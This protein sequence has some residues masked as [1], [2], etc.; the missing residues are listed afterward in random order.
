M[1]LTQTTNSKERLDLLL[2]ISNS[3]M[4]QAPEEAA[5]FARQAL[6]EAE[7]T[8]DQKAMQRAQLQLIDCY[9]PLMKNDSA[10]FLLETVLP[11]LPPDQRI[12]RLVQQGRLL[13]RQANY[14]EGVQRVFEA[15]EL[16]ESTGNQ[17]GQAQA[18]IELSDLMYYRNEFE[19]SVGFAQQAVDL[20]DEQHPADLAMAYQYMA[21]SY[22]RLEQEEL[23]LT[24]I[25]R[26]L[27]LWKMHGADLLRLGSA[28]NSKGNVLKFLERYDEATE[29]YVQYQQLMEQ[30]DSDWGRAIGNANLGHVLLLQERY[31]EALP[32]ILK[33]IPLMEALNDRS[34]L[35]ENYYHASVIY[36]ERGDFE[37]AYA[38]KKRYA[39]E[40]IDI[41]EERMEEIQQELVDKY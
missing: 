22:L 38:Y 24:K 18:Y 3:H 41:Y 36:A 25:N 19:R 37:K 4:Q 9:E 6:R 27:E 28:Y 17:L 10:L 23:A 35:A 31:A 5:A 15:L 14:D 21:D 32:Y 29:N 2:E 20:L 39:E 8:A 40:S 34:N 30:I 33:A 11:D 1:V 13:K 7:K 26:A 12:C 16:A